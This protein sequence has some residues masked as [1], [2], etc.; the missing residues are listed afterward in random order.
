MDALHVHM[1]FRISGSTNGAQTADFWLRSSDGLPLRL[2]LFTDAKTGTPIGNAHFV[3][4][5]DLRLT[6][7]SPLQ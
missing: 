2:V 6:S 7:T 3:E 4:H 5:A 1:D